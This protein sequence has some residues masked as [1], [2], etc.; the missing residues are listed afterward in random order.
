MTPASD[1]Q[2]LV[3]LGMLSAIH[4][5]GKALTLFLCL[6]RAQTTSQCRRI[7]TP[8]GVTGG[9]RFTNDKLHQMRQ[10]GVTR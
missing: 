1:Q 8:V 2:A 9:G 7:H 3:T 4:C 5:Q 10:F 6:G